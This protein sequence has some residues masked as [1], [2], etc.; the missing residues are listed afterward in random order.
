MVDLSK[1]GAALDAGC[2]TGDW[3]VRLAKKGWD[4]SAIDLSPSLLAMAPRHPGVTYQE[5]SVQDFAGP[6][7]QFDLILSVTVI[8]HITVAEEAEAAIANIARLLKPTGTFFLVEFA[9]M[10]IP[11][12]V[13]RASYMHARTA[14]QWRDLLEQEGLRVRRQVPVRFLG[15]R[16]HAL[17]GAMVR[18]IGGGSDSSG[19]VDFPAAGVGGLMTGTAW[20]LES[21]LARLPGSRVLADVIAFGCE[22]R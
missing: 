18:R 21:V 3:A 10:R 4:V 12:R 19:E 2:G 7:G 17:G 9:P 16:I 11:R 5:C 8:Q 13:S 20:G 14:R 1:P 15:E 6:D 22:K